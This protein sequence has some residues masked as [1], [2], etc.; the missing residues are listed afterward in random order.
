M[1]S[2]PDETVPHPRVSSPLR[3]PTARSFSA[4][5]SNSASIG[6][7]QHMRVFPRIALRR[8]RPS[9][10]PARATASSPL[11]QGLEPHRIHSV[12]VAAGH[13][14]AGLVERMVRQPS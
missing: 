13:S 3:A 11:H 12:E 4:L 1:I 2:S 9:E 6:R 14:A 7:S 5:G 10:A 8:A